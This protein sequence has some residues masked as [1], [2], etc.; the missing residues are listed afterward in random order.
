MFKSKKETPA[1]VAAPPEAASSQTA[2]AK[3]SDGKDKSKSRPDPILQVMKRNK[4]IERRTMKALGTNVI[5]AIVAAASLGLNVYL[6]TRPPPEPRYIVQQNDGTLTPIIPLRQPIAN[7]NAVTQVV[8]DA[9]HTL[10]AID[11]KNY[12]AQLNDASV[13][14]TKTG[15]QRYL[16]ELEGTGTLAAIKARQL[17]LSSTVT[18]P[19]VIVKEYDIG[20]IYAWDVEVPYQVSYFGAGFSQDTQVTAKITLVRI[21]TTEN[22][23]GIAIAGFNAQR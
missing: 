2:A 21:P 23:R 5:L 20:G 15:F 10:H 8:V 14:F 12:K 19:P 6:G 9:I 4:E 16:K 7:K 11:F 1:V 18:A 3:S 22:P 13:Y 17:V